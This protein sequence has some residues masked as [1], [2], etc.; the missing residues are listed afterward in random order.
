M[1]GAVFRVEANSTSF[2]SG[3]QPRAWSA[4]GCQVS[5]RGSP[6]SAGITYTSGLPLRLDVKATQ[7]PSGESWGSLSTAG[8]LV[9]R[10]A[11]PPSRGAIQRSPPYSKA[12]LVALRVGCRRRR[13][14]CAVAGR[15]AVRANPRRARRRLMESPEGGSV[16]QRGDGGGVSSN[17]PIPGGATMEIGVGDQ[18]SGKRGSRPLTPDP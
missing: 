9:S 13:V 15:G 10:F 12:M 7:R 2:P 6:P 4:A 1:A 8:V 17:R 18:G 16:E 3:D 11:S 14:P 5:L